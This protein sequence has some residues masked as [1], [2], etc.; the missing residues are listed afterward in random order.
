MDWCIELNNLYTKVSR[1]LHASPLHVTEYTPKTMNVVAGSNKTMTNLVKES[2]LIEVFRD[3]HLT[4]EKNLVL[5]HLTTHHTEPDMTA[6]FQALA[7]AMDRTSPHVHI[8]GRK[9]LFEIADMIDQGLE[10]L[11][12]S[13]WGEKVVGEEGTEAEA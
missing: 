8:R 7:G 13:N 6:T 3:C 11:M 5:N 2:V 10:G 9:A 4:L 12:A 1:I